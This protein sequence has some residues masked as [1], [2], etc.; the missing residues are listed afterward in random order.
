MKR[1][2]SILIYSISLFIV[3]IFAGCGGDQGGG[4]T[5]IAVPVSVTEIV[6]KPIEEYIVTTG[7]VSA[8]QE[9]T[10]NSESA[11]YY[12][13]LE[14]PQTNRLFALGDFVKKNQDIIRLDNPEFEN[15]IKIESQ[16]LNLEISE[17]EFEK[18]KSLHEKGGVTLR[19]L[20][21]AERVYIDA[22]YNYDNAL[23]Q[24]AKLTITSP[25]EGVIVELPYYTQGVKVESGQTMIKV[26]NYRGL[27]MEVNL[28]GKDLAR[29]QVGQEAR[30]MNYTM[31]EDTLI[32]R[33]TQVS[34]A[35]DP[36]TR[37]FTAALNIS[38]PEWQLRPGMFVKTEIIVARNDTALVIPKEIILAKRRGKTVFIVEKGAAEQRTIITGLENPNEVEVVQGLNED[39]RLVIKGFETL[40]HRSK[41]KIIR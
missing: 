29:V 7:T 27:Y 4:E 6:R 20:R 13:V 17:Q 35:I 21:D 39:E 30:I 22:K 19:E 15:N 10:L 14:N 16:K 2:K 18:Q 41:V 3:F 36:D 32:G 33:V 12:H 25:F 24:L 11:G 34:P 5:E 40:Q 31:P 9:A 37:T 8:M 38:N 28:P 23:I 1:N 26:M